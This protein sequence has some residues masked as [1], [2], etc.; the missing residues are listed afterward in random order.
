MAFIRRVRGQSVLSLYNL[1]NDKMRELWNGLDEDQQETWALFGVYP[2]FDWTPD[3]RQIVIWAKGKIWRVDVAS[4][5][6]TEIPI[7]AKVQ[8]TITNALRFANDIGGLTFPV[9]VIRWPQALPGGNTALFQA[10]GYLY[11][12]PPGGNPQRLTRQLDHYEF[13]PSLSFDGKQI[14]YVTWNDTLGGTVRIV[15]SDGRNSR[16]LVSRPGHYVDGS[17]SRD[18][19]WVVYHRGNGDG[20]RGRLW[21]ED[22]GIYLID[23]LGKSAP[24]FLTR[25]GEKPRFSCSP[26]K[27][28]R[29]PL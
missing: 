4:G 21:E 19:N 5:T 13:A 8:Q 23:A 25:D 20:Y 6:P 18:G 11:Q 17:F 2:G 28:K 29:R 22:P 10:L 9:K 14:V 7:H 24:K 3:G 16:I 1:E 15:N 26:T 27:A 12:R